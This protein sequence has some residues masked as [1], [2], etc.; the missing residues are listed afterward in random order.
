MAGILKVDQ[1]AEANSGQG[2]RLN[3]ALKNSSG[4][5]IISAAGVFSSNI[6][7][8]TISNAT[9][10]STVTF[11]AGIIIGSTFNN[12]TDTTSLA[13]GSDN[14]FVDCT[15]SETYL[16]IKSTSSKFYVV[17][18]NS[19]S[20]TT[21]GG[22]AV[23][24]VYYKKTNSGGS[25]G[26]YASITG[27]TS[28]AN[29]GV[30]QTSQPHDSNSNDTFSGMLEI[31]NQSQSVG[32]RLYCKVMIAASISGRT[33]RNNR[34]ADSGQAYNHRTISSLQIFEVAQ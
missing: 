32:D 30:T 15:G 17:W 14:G 18:M 16:T 23:L 28:G 9:L 24:N 21:N 7:G 6:D 29:L 2:V 25:G 26:S 10:D 31:S 11:P 13:V 34:N 27:V 33:I 1:I 20:N 5:E 4:T 12:Y 22:R 3:H 8:S 19:L